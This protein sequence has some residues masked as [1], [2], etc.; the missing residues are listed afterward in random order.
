[1]PRLLRSHGVCRHFGATWPNQDEHSPEDHANAQGLPH[2]HPKQH[3]AVVAT[4]VELAVRFAHILEREAG[5]S[6]TKQKQRR[7][8]ARQAVT[9]A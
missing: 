9:A 4:F 5:G 3:R 6:V 7:V 8:A 2:R 1:M